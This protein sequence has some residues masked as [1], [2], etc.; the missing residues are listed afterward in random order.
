MPTIRIKRGTGSSALANYELGFKTGNKGLYIGTPDGN[1]NIGRNISVLD[2]QS[3]YD[4]LS[5]KDAN[6]IYLIKTTST[7]ADSSYLAT[8]AT[9]A[10]SAITTATNSNNTNKSTATSLASSKQ[11]SITGAATTVLTSSLTASRALISNSSGKIA[12]SSKIS[13]TELNYLDGVTENIQTA[14]DGKMNTTDVVA[15]ANCGTGATTASAART[16]LGLKY[17]QLYSGTFTSGS[18]TVDITNQDFLVCVGRVRSTYS[19]QGWC[20]PLARVTSTAEKWQF[21]DDE[22]FFAFN[23]S[24]SGNTLTVAQ[25]GTTGGRILRIF[26]VKVAA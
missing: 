24:K 7:L 1:V 16:N 8:K 2:S 18:M 9:S 6:T 25:T 23:L 13:S 12:V 3:A 21:A 14:L 4:N 17:T 11:N 22:Y 19:T 10:E 15:L 20:I 26:G 5:T